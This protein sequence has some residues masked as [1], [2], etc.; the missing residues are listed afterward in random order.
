MKKLIFAVVF[1]SIFFIANL[2]LAKDTTNDGSL[3]EAWVAINALKVQVAD[4]QSASE[5]TGM[6]SGNFVKVSEKTSAKKQIKNASQSEH[7]VMRGLMIQ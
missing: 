3:A 7:Y 1:A 6:V 4:L 5:T 2:V